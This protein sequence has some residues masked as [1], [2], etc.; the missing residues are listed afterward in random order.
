MSSC[1]NFP[2]A[3]KEIASL[4]RMLPKVLEVPLK[5]GDCVTQISRNF[6]ATLDDLEFQLPMRGGLSPLTDP[7]RQQSPNET[8]TSVSHVFGE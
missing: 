7:R 6:V 1:L 5:R 8:G 2:A 4:L 3:N